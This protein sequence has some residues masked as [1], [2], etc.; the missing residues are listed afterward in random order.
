M[1]ILVGTSS[2]PFVLIIPFSDVIPIV[3]RISYLEELVPL[4]NMCETWL[5][6]LDVPYTEFSLYQRVLEYPG[7]FL[8]LS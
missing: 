3:P 2:V 5:E 7:Q 6:L 4:Y 1:L 8:L